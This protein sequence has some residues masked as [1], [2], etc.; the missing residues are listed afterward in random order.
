MLKYRHSEAP[1]K[2]IKVPS[3]K[4]PVKVMDGYT[5]LYL[6]NFVKKKN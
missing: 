5:F 1:F 6:Q 3:G 4:V 2:I